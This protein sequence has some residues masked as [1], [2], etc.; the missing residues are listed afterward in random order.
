MHSDLIPFTPAPP[1][2]PALLSG[3]SPHPG[4]AA[5]RAAPASPSPGDVRASP[6]HLPAPALNKQDNMAT[7]LFP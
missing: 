6:A 7:P 5:Q 1:P 4:G 3:A 2:S